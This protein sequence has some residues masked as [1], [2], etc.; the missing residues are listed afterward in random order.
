MKCHTET[1]LGFNVATTCYCCELIDFYNTRY[2]VL[3]LTALIVIL[4]RCI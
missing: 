2:T 1:V 4:R 3:S